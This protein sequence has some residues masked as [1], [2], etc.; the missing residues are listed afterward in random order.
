MC[1]AARV[2]VDASAY[3]P[4]PSQCLA[5]AILRVRLRA[6]VGGQVW[7][8]GVL[9]G[10]ALNAFEM[11]GQGHRSRLSRPTFVCNEEVGPSAPPGGGGGGG[12]I[13]TA[14]DMAATEKQPP[15]PQVHHQPLSGSRRGQGSVGPASGRRVSTSCLCWASAVTLSVRGWGGPGGVGAIPPRS[16]GLGG[17]SNT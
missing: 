8:F 1:G 16:W 13:I 12:F 10:R 9:V 3:A 14:W 6:T 7:A 5:W 2:G 4:P 15:T 11:G 17:R